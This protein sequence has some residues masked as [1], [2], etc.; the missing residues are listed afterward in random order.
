MPGRAGAG[1][2]GALCRPRRQCVACRPN[3]QAP[4]EPD[5]ILKLLHV[6]DHALLRDALGLLLSQ[7]WPGLQVL[8]AGSLADACATADAHPDLRLVL[9]DLGLPDAQGLHSLR[10]LQAHAPHARHV[11]LS[12]SDAPALVLQAI[13]AGAAGF[14]PKTA[15]L[16]QMR[17]ALQ[18]VLDGGIHLPPGLALPPATSRAGTATEPVLTAR[19]RDVLGLLVDGLPN[20]TISR[21]LGLSASTVKTHMEAIYRQLGVNSR[22]QAVVVAARLGLHLPLDGPPR[23]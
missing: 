8:H 13:D 21:Q 18:R 16:G 17:S 6:D 2:G 15:D 9:V 1:L 19:Q 22:A 10:V 5:P 20:K 12:A 3:A 14:V 23:P 4:A 7:T 11:V